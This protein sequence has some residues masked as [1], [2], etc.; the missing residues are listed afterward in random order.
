[1]KRSNRRINTSLQKTKMCR[2]IEAGKICPN[3][4]SCTYAHKASE[5]VKRYCRYGTSCQ[6]VERTNGCYINRGTILCKEQHENETD[7][8]FNIRLCGVS[9][10]SVEFYVSKCIAPDV[11][12]KAI[13]DGATDIRIVIIGDWADEC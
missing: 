2:L 9:P 8:N 3:G 6:Y 1:M 5:L 10:K 12:Q 7:E 13:K 4:S 11:L